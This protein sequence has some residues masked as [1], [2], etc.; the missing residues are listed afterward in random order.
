MESPPDRGIDRV[1]LGTALAA[2]LGFVVWGV[3][4]AD[5]LSRAAQAALDRTLSSTGWLYVA[6]TTGLV[7]FALFL[8]FSR[9]GRIRLG[10]DDERPEFSTKA[11]T[12][13]LFAAGMGIGLVFWGIAEPLSHLATPPLGAAEPRSAEA[14]RLAMEYTIFHW[15]LHPWALYALVGLALAFGIF[16]RGRPSL[17]SSA[18]FPGKS[19]SSWPSR[20]VDVFAVFLTTFGA[21]TSLGLGALQINSGLASNFGI[22][23]NQGVGVAIVAGLMLLFVLSAVTG[24]H[25]GIKHISTINAVLAGLL[26]AFVFIA[27]PSTHLL[28]TF[29]EAL[30]GYTARIVPMATQTGAYGGEEWVAGWTVFYWAW[31]MA[32]CPF[33]GT[34][35][36]RI[37]RGRTVREFIVGVLVV[38]TVVSLAWF[39]VM[40][41]TAMRLELS[42]QA[43][44][45]QALADSGEEG[46]LFAM[47]DHL[48]LPMV[49]SV[50][51]MALIALFF[52]S[53]A[54]SASVVL[55]MFCQRGALAPHRSL[56]VVWGIAIAL[57]AAVLLLTGGLSAIQ[58]ASIVLALPFLL[59]IVVICIAFF[60]ELRKE[61]GSAPAAF[62]AHEDLP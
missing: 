14:S 27:G 32:Y 18:V 4:D 9:Y 12:A 47:F 35:I 46:V 42:G 59:L 40:G 31:W 1:V 61:A 5:S 24:V 30:G 33:V 29:I 23:A 13:M 52:V 50:I 26:L 58:T 37:S 62:S 11:W 56:I 51:V 36:A 28:Q 3:V 19:P 41:G 48:P 39:A 60:R 49:T 17:L 21:A 2:C 25:R 53:S 22:P 8:A 16:R 43:P 10:R 57:T 38:P 15:G 20:A 44:L 55:G 6:V 7:V 54:D 34:F 45:S